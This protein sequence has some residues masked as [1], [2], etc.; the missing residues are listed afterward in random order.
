MTKLIRTLQVSS[1]SLD[2]V[3]EPAVNLLKKGEILA[4]P[5][6]TVYGLGA[7]AF[8]KDAVAKIYSAK[9]R[10][11]DNPLIVHISDLKMLKNVIDENS[12]IPECVTKLIDVFWPG[13]LTILFKKVFHYPICNILMLQFNRIPTFQMKSHVVLI[14]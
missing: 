1:P 8:Q 10:P 4:F 12:N 6:E 11:C 7:N 14:M 2:S 13:P 9:Q 3:L 5:T